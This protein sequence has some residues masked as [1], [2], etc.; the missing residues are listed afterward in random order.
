MRLSIE[1]VPSPIGALTCVTLGDMLFTLE[2]EENVERVRACLARRGVA[3]NA[4]PRSPTKTEVARRIEAYFEGDLSAIEGVAAEVHGTPFEQRVYAEL[5]KIPTGEVVSYS[6]LARRAGRP[7]AV[8]ATGAT[9]AKNPI[10]I[11]VPCHRVI[12]ANGAL[13]GYAGG[14]ER[15]QWLLAHE[16]ARRTEKAR[17]RAVRS[18]RAGAPYEVG[19][20]TD[21]CV[22]Q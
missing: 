1:R 14:V 12:G 2:F 15:K 11:V 3:L 7:R 21:Q 19:A 5:R 9:N 17:E 20:P 6:E 10:A 18:R 16:G 13:T 22:C 8:R 4:V